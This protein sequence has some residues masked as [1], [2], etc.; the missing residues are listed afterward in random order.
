[1]TCRMKIAP[2]ALVS[3]LLLAVSTSPLA[4]APIPADDV[5]VAARGWL[6]LTK[7]APLGDALGSGLSFMTPG[8][9]EQGNL[10]YYAVGLEAG[11]VLVMAPDDAIDPVIAFSPET[12][13]LSDP[14]PCNHLRTMLEADLA[15]RLA[16]VREG[17]VKDADAK[18]A[19]WALL[20]AAARDPEG[21]KAGLGSVSDVRV[22]PLTSTK[23]SQ[24]FIY[25]GSTKVA[26]YNYYTPPYGAGNA[27]NYYCG[28]VATTFAQLMYFHKHPKKGVGTASM[29][30]YVNG[31]SYVRNLR[32]GNGTGGPYDWA[33]MPADAK[34]VKLS[35]TQ[36]MAIGALCADAGVADRMN[37][38]AGGSSAPLCWSGGAHPLLTVFKFAN[39]VSPWVS[40]TS[41]FAKSDINQALNPS[42]DAGLPA[43]LAM[44]NNKGGHAVVVDGYGYA[45]G[46][47]YHHL[48][49]GWGGV[50]TAWY[51][52]PNVDAGSTPYF[53]ITGLLF[54]L[55]PTESGFS[56][57]SGR[58]LDAAG[59][60]VAGAKVVAKHTGDMYPNKSAI[61]NSRGIYAIAVPSGSYQVVPSL[62]GFGFS[63]VSKVAT[64]G[65][66]TVRNA[67]FNNFKR[68]TRI[69]RLSTAKLSF[70]TV[71]VTDDKVLKFTVFNDGTASLT[72]NA[73]A[74]P[75]AFFTDPV[76][77]F[78]VPA[79][80]GSVKVSVH[81]SP[82]AA[83]FVKGDLI[84]KS[85]KSAGVNTL[86]VAGTGE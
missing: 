24:S 78:T 9:D 53:R 29:P 41:S 34:S 81:F 31:D 20:M 51:N 2:V 40:E 12:G 19:K 74:G 48:N 44:N 59:K 36:R 50:D 52:L 61:S 80:G 76:P 30:I 33:N 45:Y 49:L 83:G 62:A 63:P 26:V 56:L 58:L 75:P 69:I 68:V 28:C 10:L 5:V 17:T 13:D 35:A 82:T 77:P 15:D 21:V 60:P 46:S 43:A 85:N 64:V 37:Y 55:S 71:A 57:I 66:T 6:A 39:V 84:V 70:G 18:A 67:W 79:N 72:V 1:M 22:G 54:N 32:G 8:N 7:S 47:L 14:D 23:W 86:T 42:L 38:S 3:V 25:S 11:G 16:G 4:A 65:Y 73:F 27:L